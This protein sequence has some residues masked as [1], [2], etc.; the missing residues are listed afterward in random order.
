MKPIW[1]IKSGEFAGH[2]NGD[3]V[4]NADGENVGCISGKMVG[5]ISGYVIGEMYNDRLVGYRTN[6]AYSLY[7]LRAKYASISAMRYSDTTGHSVSGW[8][9]PHF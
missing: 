1:K 8:E 3:R 7:G 4:Y 6:A 9:D 5:G 2:I